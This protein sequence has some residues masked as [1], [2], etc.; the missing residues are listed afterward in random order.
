[1]T[2]FM[3]QIKHIQLDYGKRKNST[4]GLDIRFYVTCETGKRK[5][6]SM[7]LFQTQEWHWEAKQI[8]LNSKTLLS[9]SISTKD[10][11][12]FALCIQQSKSFFSQSL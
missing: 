9:L 12:S 6:I 1:M 10:N 2:S 7:N 3:L 8:G 5:L 4:F 11:I